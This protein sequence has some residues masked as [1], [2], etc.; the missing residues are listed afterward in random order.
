[1]LLALMLLA[2]SVTTDSTIIARSTDGKST[3]REVRAH[4]PEGGGS[5]T[6][7]LRSAGR[8][9]LDLELSSNFGT[10]GPHKPQLVS[11]ATCS[12]RLRELERELDRRGFTG[13]TTRP[14]RCRGS[15]REDLVTVTVRRGP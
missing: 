3:L 9:A 14:E 10:G 8:R 7:S 6:Y 12:E 11:A 13:V 2:M 1:M 4:G 5:L 15:D